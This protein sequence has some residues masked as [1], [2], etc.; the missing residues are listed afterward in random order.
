LNRKIRK[1]RKGLE[2]LTGDS[3][4]ILPDLPDLS[5]NLNRT[6]I[7]GRRTLGARRP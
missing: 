4:L 1:V 7:L 2:G 5:V 6:R 3:A